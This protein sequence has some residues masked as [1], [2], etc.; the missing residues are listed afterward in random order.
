MAPPLWVRPDGAGAVPDP[1]PDDPE[2]VFGA[3]LAAVA[4]GLGVAFTVVVVR[5]GAVVD[6]ALRSFVVRTTATAFVDVVGATVV[7]TSVVGTV[8]ATSPVACWGG[9][10]ADADTATASPV[11]TCGGIDDGGAD[12][13]IK[14]SA[15]APAIAAQSAMGTARRAFF[16]P[17]VVR[18]PPLMEKRRGRPSSASLLK[19]SQRRF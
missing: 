3:G 19:R 8:V 4:A 10:G 12:T 7:G 6:G 9:S 16:N 17:R 11:T 5:R 15:G 1:D 13:C 18:T 2:P 14:A